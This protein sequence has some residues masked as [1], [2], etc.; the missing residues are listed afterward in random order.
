[1]LAQGTAATGH[2]TVIWGDKPEIWTKADWKGNVG[3]CAEGTRVP[4][5]AVPTPVSCKISVNL[6][7]K[8]VLNHLGPDDSQDATDAGA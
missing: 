3:K 1:M 8:P 5:T 6:A 4:S 2:A 7:L